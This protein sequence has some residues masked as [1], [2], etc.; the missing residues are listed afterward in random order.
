[1]QRAL[2]GMMRV[3]P[4]EVF[5][6]PMALV[7]PFYVVFNAKGARAIYRYYRQRLLLGRFQACTGVLWNHLLF[8]AVVIDRFAAFAGRKFRFE[9]ENLPIFEEL[10]KGEKGFLMLSSH[11]G[12]YELAGYTLVS[13]NKTFNAVVYEGESETVMKSR[14]ALLTAN[15]MRLVPVRPDMSHLFTINAALDRGEIVSMPAD[16]LNGSPKAVRCDLLDAPVSLP[17]G[18]F[19]LAKAK[20]VPMLAVFVMKEGFRRYRIFVHRVDGPQQFANALQLVLL[21]YPAQWFNF[22]DFWN[23][24]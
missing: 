13:H 10:A 8:G 5:Y 15:N 14:A 4:H 1:M 18:V 3:V 24:Q 9:I 12:C 19:A 16:R 11:V 23:Q 7:V 21:C 17:R 6:V 22:Y 20:E 2:V